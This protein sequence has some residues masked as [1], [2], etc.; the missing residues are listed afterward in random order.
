MP[1]PFGTPFDVNNFPDL[2]PKNMQDEINESYTHDKVLPRQ[3]GK[4]YNE[5]AQDISEEGVEKTT[6]EGKD[7]Y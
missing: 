2:Y 4:D 5:T 7:N 1:E 3:E 6:S